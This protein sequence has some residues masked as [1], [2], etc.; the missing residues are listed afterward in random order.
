VPPINSEISIYGEHLGCA[1]D[2]GHW[3]IAIP[4]QERA[5]ISLL[6]LNRET[7]PPHASGEM[8]LQ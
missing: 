1:E 4:A 8:W 7:D 2:L 5:K 3:P 6:A